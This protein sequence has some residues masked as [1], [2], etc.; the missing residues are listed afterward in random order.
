MLW[1]QHLPS[2]PGGPPSTSLMTADHRSAFF[3]WGLH[4]LVSANEM[5]QGHMFREYSLLGSGV[6]SPLEAARDWTT[7]SPLHEQQTCKKGVQAK[8]EVS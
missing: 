8:G 3:F 7:R 2:L 1:S 4:E 5:V 6:R